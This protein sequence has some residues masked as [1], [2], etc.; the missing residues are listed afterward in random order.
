MMAL[1]LLSGVFVLSQRHRA[2]LADTGRPLPRTGRDAADRE[3]RYFGW[4]A[5]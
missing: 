5:W 4:L 3:A 2:V 1:V